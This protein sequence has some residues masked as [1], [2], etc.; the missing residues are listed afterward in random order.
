MTTFS[1]CR[2]QLLRASQ[3]VF[4]EKSVSRISFKQK[5][6]ASTFLTKKFFL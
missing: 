5:L 2:Y 4:P 6:F 1:V 3:I